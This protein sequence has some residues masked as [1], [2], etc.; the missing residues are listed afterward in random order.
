[1][2]ML[3]RVIVPTH[4]MQ[5]LLVANGLSPDKVAFSQYGIRP[6]TP[7]PHSKD[8][9]GKVRIGFIGGLSEHKGAHL[10]ISA[11]RLLPDTVSVELKI[12]GKSDT[13]PRYFKKLQQ[14]SAGDQRI[15]FCGTFQN[16]IIDK[17]F[18]KLDVLVVPSI[19]Y[20]NTPLVIYSAQAA[21]CPVIASNL[22]GM[23]EVVE[24]EK[25]GLLFE[26]GDVTGLAAAIE[27][28]ARDRG[29]L[30]Q[31]A[32]NAVKPKS[33]SGYVNELMVIY[34]DVLLEQRGKK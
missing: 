5:E 12:Y 10:L 21:G 15:Y 17:I 24:H 14:L 3:D 23:A 32:A 18:A 31:L 26:V 25:N 27:R 29:L 13:D 7:E 4:L 19:W 11:I 8:A 16:Q 9:T 30:R 6:T 22:G 33:I 1:M 20:E 2:N 34:D 28:I